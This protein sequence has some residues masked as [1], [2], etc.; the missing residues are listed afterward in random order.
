MEFSALWAKKAGSYR[1][2]QRVLGLGVPGAS[3]SEAK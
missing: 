2:R 3:A 1:D